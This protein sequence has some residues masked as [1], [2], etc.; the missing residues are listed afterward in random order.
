MTYDVKWYHFSQPKDSNPIDSR[1]DDTLVERI[2]SL[3]DTLSAFADKLGPTTRLFSIFPVLLS[4]YDVH[5]IVK[6]P[7]TGEWEQICGVER[8]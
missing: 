2:R 7:A 1:P 8:Y 6:L 4:L 3:G 5:I